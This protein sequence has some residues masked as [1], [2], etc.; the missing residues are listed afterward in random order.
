M[1]HQLS[2]ALFGTHKIL[3]IGVGSGTY[4]DRYSKTYLP[5][6]KFEWTGVEIWEPYVEKFGLAAKYDHLEITDASIFLSQQLTAGVN[7]DICFMG[8]V[9]EHV[10]KDEAVK[11]VE[12]AVQTCNAVILSIPIIHY[13][14]EEYE[15]N[16]YEKHVKDDWSHQEVM[17]TFGELVAEYGV[18]SEIGVYVLSKKKYNLLKLVLKP[19]IACYAICKNEESFIDRFYES[20]HEAD[21]ISIVDTGSTDATFSKLVSHV[22]HRAE[23]HGHEEEF[24]CEVGADGFLKF[25]SDGEMIVQRAWVNPWRFDDARNIALCSLPED[26]DVCISIDI[27]ELLEP[28][29]KEVLSKAILDD[30]H[31]QGRPADRYH[32]RFSTIWNWKDPEPHNFSDHWHERIHSRKGYRWKLPVHEVLVKDGPEQVRWLHD[33]K[34]VQ[35]PDLSKSRS[36]YLPLLE[37]AIREDPTRWKLFSFYAGEL[38]GVNRLSEAL[39]A[40]RKAKELPSADRAFLSFQASGMHRKLGDNKK[41]LAEMMTAVT[42]A[43]DREYRVWLARLYRDLNKPREA[44][45]AVLMAAEV[46]ERSYGYAYDPSCWGEQ[47]DALVNELTVLAYTRETTST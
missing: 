44:L 45:N 42:E 16:P 10:S 32:H 36:S 8:D 4:S 47:F 38:Q 37:Q 11:M 31:S 39:E 17:E 9:V 14:Q 18:E 3:D 46:T 15:G 5:R 41:A 28:G 40:I 25:A 21:F 26:P 2:H 1:C 6:S 33:L 22:L 20:I 35:K 29:W 30:L 7:Y 23:Q 19:Q 24:K 13:P 12:M 43:P 27:D 34:M